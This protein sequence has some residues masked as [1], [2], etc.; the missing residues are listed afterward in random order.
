[1]KKLLGIVILLSF[2]CSNGFTNDFKLERSTVPT[3]DIPWLRDS[4][5][6]FPPEEDYAIAYDQKL[7]EKL[8]KNPDMVQV[9]PG[10]EFTPGFPRKG[11]TSYFKQIRINVNSSVKHDYWISTGL[12]A[13]AG[14]KIT[15][16]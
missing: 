1:M 8:H 2:W 15:V 5:N 16:P 14:K 4:N 7:I 12:Y 9:H 3:V 6:N 11:A 10:A 13:S